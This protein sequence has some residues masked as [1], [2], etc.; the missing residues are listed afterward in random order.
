MSSC[1]G[2]NEWRRVINSNQSISRRAKSGR[3]KGKRNLASRIVMEG[4]Q[5]HSSQLKSYSVCVSVL[6]NKRLFVQIRCSSIATWHFQKRVQCVS[7]T[8]ID[9]HYKPWCWRHASCTPHP[10]LCLGCSERVS[11]L[12]SWF[13]KRRPDSLTS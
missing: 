1:A 10:H 5:C 8:T 13:S 2:A 7:A 4:A 9:A 6:H 12:L 11:H 3:K